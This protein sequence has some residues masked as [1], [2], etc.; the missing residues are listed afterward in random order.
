[1]TGGAFGSMIA[2][3]F[4]L[5]ARRA[6]DAARRGRRG[7]HVGDVRLAGRGR[8]ARRRAAA[9]R[10][11]AAQPDPGRA[12]QRHGRGRCAATSR[13]RAA[14]SR[15]R[16]TRSSSAPKASSACVLAGIL[17]GA[18]SALLT[19]RRLRRRGR[20]PEAAAS[21][22]CGGPRSAAWSSAWAESSFR[23]RWASAT[24]HRRSAAGRVAAAT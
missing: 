11:E 14:L 18:L 16:R 2:Q 12:R 21:T 24:N 20:V 19:A 17:A 3:L 4:H 5:T 9:V 23:R 10:V 8:A 1:M 22:G 6:Q 7:G 15:S 13:T